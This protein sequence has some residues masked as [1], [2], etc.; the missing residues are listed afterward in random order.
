MTDLAHLAQILHET[1]HRE[2]MGLP[3]LLE[4]VTQE[5]NGARRTAERSRR[6]DSDAAAVQIMTVWVTGRITV[7]VYCCCLVS[8][9]GTMSVTVRETWT[10][11]GTCRTTV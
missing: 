9:T 2:R 1:A 10:V 11:S 3:A 6:L 7:V 5:C 4:W 8:V